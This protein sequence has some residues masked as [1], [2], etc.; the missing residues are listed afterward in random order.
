[1]VTYIRGARPLES[2]FSRADIDAVV[3]IYDARSGDYGT[4]DLDAVNRILARYPDVPEEDKQ[5]LTS[6]AGFQTR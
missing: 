1:M 4:V 6:Y 2:V 5:N 3:R